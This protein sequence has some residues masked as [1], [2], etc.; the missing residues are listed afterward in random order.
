M[1]CLSVLPVWAILAAREL[2]WGAVFLSPIEINAEGPMFSSRVLAYKPLVYP[3]VA[4]LLVCSAYVAVRFRVDRVLMRAIKQRSFPWFELLVLIVAMLGSS[5]AE[6]HMRCAVN[7]LS[8]REEIFEELV[9][10]VA[11][12]ALW[13]AQA[14]VLDGPQRN[15][16]L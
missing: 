6:G 10:L 2:S 1:L 9:E 4:F 7:L 12:A 15:S 11:Y 5:C 8:T 14:R 3:A 16:V 13:L